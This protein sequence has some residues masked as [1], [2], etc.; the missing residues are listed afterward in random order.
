MTESERVPTQ[1]AW[2]S[3]HEDRHYFWRHVSV[4]FTKAVREVNVLEGSKGR[5]RHWDRFSP[6]WDRPG[7]DSPDRPD[8]VRL[9][10]DLV[11]E[12]GPFPWASGAADHLAELTGVTRAE[13]ALILAGLPSLNFA[14]HNFLEAATRKQLGLKA[15]EAV[16]ARTSLSR[17]P[18]HHRVE[19]VAA[20]LPDEP[21]ELWTDPGHAAARHVAETWNRLFGRRLRIPD[22]LVVAVKP[23][24]HGLPPQEA[25]GMVADPERSPRLNSDA[26]WWVK[27]G[28]ELSW[29]SKTQPFFDLFS[30]QAVARLVPWLFL[31]L[32]VGDPVRSQLPR[33]IDLARRRLE[34]PEL[35]VGGHWLP[36]EVQGTSLPDLVSGPRYQPPEGPSLEASRDGGWVVLFAT[37]FGRA[38]L[39]P[40]RISGREDR[41]V[42]RLLGQEALHSMVAFIRGAG[43]GA[44]A[45]RV[46][47]TPVAAGGF[48]ADPEAGVPELVAEVANHTQLSRPAAGLYLQ[49]LALAEPSVRNVIRWNAWPAATYA[50][51]AGELVERGVVVN[52]KRPRAGREIF[53]PG[54][55]QELKAPNLP[56]E[57]WKL[58]LYD[59]VGIGGRFLP[60]S[61]LHE[62]FEMAWRR[63]RGGDAPGF[64]GS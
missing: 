55:W 30:L 64:G 33:V 1:G 28:G 23:E 24:L 14:R 54:P 63:V 21:R 37:T 46:R 29:S 22:E 31:N 10:V 13:A 6:R 25:L 61:P 16:A 9:L 42:V 59:N 48:E 35:L 38:Y 41:N 11:R 50:G 4:D 3:V 51:A 7:A 2:L 52:G 36:L 43:A 45:E 58:P 32:P 44:M 57:A 40:S 27:P 20:C 8:R 47:R 18:A 15:T 26:R 19:L 5:H 39:R 17:L 60:M 49:V 34:N 12:K 56:L 62:L 53:L